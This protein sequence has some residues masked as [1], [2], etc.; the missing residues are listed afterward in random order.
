MRQSQVSKLFKFMRR[1]LSRP[2]QWLLKVA[3][4]VGRIDYSWRRPWK[5]RAILAGLMGIG[6]VVLVAGQLRAATLDRAGNIRGQINDGTATSV[7]LQTNADDITGSEKNLTASDWE[8]R[9]GTFTSTSTNTATGFNIFLFRVQNPHANRNE[10]FTVNWVGKSTTTQNP[11]V[12]QA[13]KWRGSATGWRTIAAVAPSASGTV[14][15]VSGTVFTA[16]STGFQMDHFY[17]TDPS[18]CLM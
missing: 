3:G 13:Y 10:H 4:T 5:R 7:H 18:S 17:D 2:R 15:S 12:L 11:V 16:S 1:R 6:L 8:T 9:D 14:F